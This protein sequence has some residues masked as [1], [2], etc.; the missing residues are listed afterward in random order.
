MNK[1]LTKQEKKIIKEALV[2]KLYAE[3]N[4]ERWLELRELIKEMGK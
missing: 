1:E 3:E 2:I 4:P